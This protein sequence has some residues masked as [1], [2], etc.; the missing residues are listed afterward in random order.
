MGNKVVVLALD[1][2]TYDTLRP[3][4]ERGEMPNLK[5]LLEIGI[6]G[7]LRSTLPPVSA[8]AWASFQTGKNPGK[9]GIFDF[10]R[11]SSDYGF[12]FINSTHLG[13][14][15]IWFMMVKRGKR[16]GLINV[17]FTYPP[18][19]HL[20]DGSFVISGNRRSQFLNEKAAFTYPEK[21]RDEIYRF[22]P[23]FK[24]NIFVRRFQSIEFLED[25]VES[26]IKSEELNL[27]LYDKYRPDFYMDHYDMPDLL[28]HFFWRHL[29]PMH[30]H[31]SPGE[32][33]IFLPLI[34]KCFGVLDRIIGNRLDMLDGDTT[35]IIMSDHGGGTCIKNV[36]INRWLY[37][38]SYLV[39]GK[40]N[41]KG[42]KALMLKS[43]LTINN[44]IRISKS[45]DIFNLRRKFNKWTRE[46]LIQ[47]IDKVIS[48]D[49]DWT[50][51]YAYAGRASEWAVHINLRGRRQSG[52]V[53]PGKEYE[54]LRNEIAEGLLELKD[55]ENGRSVFNR[56]YKREEI[57]S[58]PAL[59]DAPDLVLDV[60]E[61][62]Y[63]VDSRLSVNRVLEDIPSWVGGGMHKPCGMLA[64]VGK[65]IKGGFEVD[66]A[67]ILDLA[68]TILYAMGLPVPRDM[69]GKVLTQCFR[70]DCLKKRRVE[71]EEALDEA[72]GTGRDD[73]HSEKEVELM[74]R[75][76]RDLGYF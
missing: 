40:S 9:H 22:D 49:V 43:G 16:V 14:K 18:P 39:Y 44:L 17:F 62:P 28:L 50:R 26:T 54:T 42:L 47:K 8:P 23:E 4:V 73:I 2:G 7:P 52:I 53:S 13:R 59:E 10:A 48:A 69:D 76:L 29:D 56:I 60:G 19:D 12:T 71:Y 20:G 11:N 21:L 34:N 36:H 31:H 65:G 30:P 5:R 66:S 3:R 64:I 41:V 38:N 75:R 72:E 25:L 61:R 37:E 32:A 35:L 57:Y 63:L 51:T 70:E 55:Q 1:G 46:G 6:H 67:S 58:C 74:K 33:K 27:H 68:P 24:W 45:I 15:P